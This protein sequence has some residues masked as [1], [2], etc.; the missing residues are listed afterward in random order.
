MNTNDLALENIESLSDSADVG[1]IDETTDISDDSASQIMAGQLN[2]EIEVERRNAEI[3][4]DISTEL[5][6]G[7]ATLSGSMTP[8]DMLVLIDQG[9]DGSVSDTE[10]E[11]VQ[12]QYGDTFVANVAS[13]NSDGLTQAI[14][15]LSSRGGDDETAQDPGG[16]LVQDLAN[17]DKVGAIDTLVAADTSNS[18]TVTAPE[19]GQFAGVKGDG[20][21]SD[22]ELSRLSEAL[23]SLQAGD[24]GTSVSITS[25][26]AGEAL[27]RL[28]SDSAFDNMIGLALEEV[29]THLDNSYAGVGGDGAVDTATE[30]A[31]SGVIGLVAQTTTH[32]NTGAYSGVID[33][34]MDIAAAT[35][36]SE[37]D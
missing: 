6:P 22:T 34:N 15:A 8:G 3:N 9:L 4:A 21:I 30:A 2:R 37:D 36:R 33:T 7:D 31:G 5:E 11:Q 29:L 32:N 1:K 35:A 10:H 19:A 17:P 25:N 12:S 13:G 27:N 23:D 14:A 16:V 24:S 20:N 26:I 28:V 18:N